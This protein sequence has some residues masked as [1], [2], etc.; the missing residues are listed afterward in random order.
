[1]TTRPRSALLFR[2]VHAVLRLPLSVLLVCCEYQPGRRLEVGTAPRS[3]LLFELLLVRV[4]D[5]NETVNSQ[6]WFEF[7]GYDQ[8]HE[9]VILGVVW[10]SVHGTQDL[11]VGTSSDLR[12]LVLRAQSSLA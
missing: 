8:S 1:M 9:T 11:D 12:I 3:V 10:S 7:S 5:T 6:S 4:Q 2:V